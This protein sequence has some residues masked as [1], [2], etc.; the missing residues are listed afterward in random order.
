MVLCRVS[1]SKYSYVGRFE[2]IF[3]VCYRYEDC[4]ILPKNKFHK[5]NMF[6]W[7]FSK[8]PK[9]VLRSVSIDIRIQ[10]R[11]LNRSKPRISWNSGAM[12]RIGE[13]ESSIFLVTYCK[14]ILRAQRRKGKQPNGT[15]SR[16][17]EILD[18][19]TTSQVLLIDRQT[20]FQNPKRATPLNTH[21]YLR[22]V[23][24]KLC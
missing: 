20:H 22:S 16:A 10:P 7:C 14:R 1:Y 9:H 2:G 15:N 21:S 4:C 17:G 6:F 12:W 8:L 18:K 19:F 13:E 11:R 24:S 23:L 3:A 5:K